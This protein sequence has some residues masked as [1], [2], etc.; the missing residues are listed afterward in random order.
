M[1]RRVVITGLG[2]VNPLGNSVEDFW[3]NVR[4]VENGIERIKR[5]D[6]TEY[7]VKIA[8]TVKDFDPG[9]RMDKKEAKRNDL[10]SQYGL[11]A[12]IE[13]MEDAGL[14][15]GDY[16]P[17]RIGVILGN[18]IGGIGTLEENIHKTMERGRMG[19]HPL[20]V[21]K[22][23]SN[24]GPAAL[25]I[26]YN[27]QGPC[28]S[29]VTAC[30]SGPDAIGSAMRWIK[31]GA[32]DMMITGG[33]EA[34]ITHVALAGFCVLQSLSKRNDEPDK[35][36]R[37]FDRD[38]DGFIIGEGAGIIILEELE[39]AKKRG[40]KIYAECAGY[41]ISCDAYH[42]TAPHPDG[43]GGIAA[44]KMAVE[45]AGLKP[46]DIDYINAHGTSTTLNDPIETKA[47]KVV[48]GEHARKLKVSSTKSMTGHLL[49]GA[50]GIEAV[51]TSLALY[52][53]Y[54]PATRNYTT[55]DPECDLDYVPNK[56]Y[57]GEIRAALSNSLGFG[58]HNGILCL[59]RYVP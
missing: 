7:P 17:T 18:G 57:N 52:H 4:N 24:I 36:S 46:W 37:P 40:A 12:G 25:A 1:E 16:D 15:E 3:K 14:K 53:Q 31:L 11:Y 10:F 45:T 56:G 42:F 13:A 50:G 27:A 35:A 6:T 30:S 8:A 41:G 34:P 5:I 58:G 19:V 23:I 33:T 2:T 47:I 29:V 44:M 26:K 51:V 43:R 21:P 32:V 54:F 9:I 22:M 28:Y 59:K 38:R 39:H 20:L 49:G 55:P 48:F